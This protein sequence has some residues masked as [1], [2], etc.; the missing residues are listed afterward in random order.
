M[1]VRNH[2]ENHPTMALDLV[3]TLLRN[4]IEKVISQETHE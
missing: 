2:W 3:C 1:L 4:Q